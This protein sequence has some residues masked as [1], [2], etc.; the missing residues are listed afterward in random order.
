MTSKPRRHRVSEHRGPCPVWNLEEQITLM[1]RDGNGIVLNHPA[2]E[3]GSLPCLA[4]LVRPP[5]PEASEMRGLRFES[6][7]RSWMGVVAYA[8]DRACTL[9]CDGPFRWGCLTLTTHLPPHP[10]HLSMRTPPWIHTHCSR[11]TRWAR[12]SLCFRLQS[13][14]LDAHLKLLLIAPLLSLSRGGCEHLQVPSLLEGTTGA[15]GAIFLNLTKHSLRISNP[16]RTPVIV[17]LDASHRQTCAVGTCMVVKS[18]LTLNHQPC[19]Q[20]LYQPVPRSTF[21]LSQE[22]L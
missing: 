14:A 5:L 15:G 20:V 4:R 10:S 3:P 22:L 16:I 18:Q 11:Y 8:N 19:S 21:L 17:P 2:L 13:A 1:V 9:A 12:G 7:R 6:C